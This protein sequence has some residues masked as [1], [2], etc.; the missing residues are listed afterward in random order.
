[1][2][3]E[4]LGGQPLSGTVTVSAAKNAALPILAGSIL[5]CGSTIL[6][7]L[8]KVDDVS[9]LKGIMEFLGVKFNYSGTCASI[10]TTEI[11]TYLLPKETSSKLRASILLAGPLLAKYGEVTISQPG[12]CA[13]GNRPID[14]HL[15]GLKSLGAKIKRLNKNYLKINASK[16]IGSTINLPFPSMGATENILMA[17][18]LAQGK[19]TINNAAKEPE[20]VDL[21]T[22]LTKMGADIKGVGTSIIKINGVKELKKCRHSIMPDRIEAGTFIMLAS[23]G[24]ELEINNVVPDHLSKVI[25]VLDLIGFRI[26]FDPNRNTAKV[27][28]Q[29]PLKP[30]KVVAGPYPEFPTDLQPILTSILSLVNGS[31]IVT[32]TVFPNRFCYTNELKK[33]GANISI[34]GNSANVKGIPNFFGADVYSPDLRGGAAL[35]VAGLLAHGKT[36]IRNYNII[37][38][39]YENFIDKLVGLGASVK[40]VDHD[41]LY[42]KLN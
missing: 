20:I 6:E 8:P 40:L 25:K 42:K 39:G 36:T 23:T 31:S 24:G 10:K 33:F 27:F 4:I 7:N 14:I 28:K 21:A 9:I 37:T 30:V 5:S 35:I 22:F 12:G 26:R 11:E 13:I 19:T 2:S 32:D 29:S 1:M 34:V 17:A 18:C 16:L 15:N 38:R 41:W 3:L